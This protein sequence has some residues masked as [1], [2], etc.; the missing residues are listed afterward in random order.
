MQ[1]FIKYRELNSGELK[2]EE[3]NTTNEDTTDVL[4][5]EE[6]DEMENFL[7]RYENRLRIVST[8]YDD[9]SLTREEL[10]DHY[11]K[12]GESGVESLINEKVGKYEGTDDIDEV[13]FGDLIKDYGENGLSLIKIFDALG[14]ISNGDIDYNCVLERSNDE[15]NNISDKVANDYNEILDIVEAYDEDVRYD[16]YSIA[17]MMYAN[18]EVE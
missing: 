16:L 6:I 12:D 3:E 4:D 17:E 1:Y 5:S 11:L 8:Y 9:G 2:Q 10:L 15:Y 13:S 14:C 18:E 7:D